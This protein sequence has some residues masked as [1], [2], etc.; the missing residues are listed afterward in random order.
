MRTFVDTSALYALLDEDD[1]NHRA[2]AAWLHDVGADVNERL[3]THNYIVVETAALVQRRLGALAL[4]VLFD[5]MIPALSVLFVDEER[6]ARA[7]AGHLAAARRKPSLVDWVSFQ[8]VHDLALDRAF[9]FDR[10]FAREG[11]TIVP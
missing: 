8:L 6:H 9:V 5:A 1:D 10:D 11:I 7:V 2:A 3:I 4:R